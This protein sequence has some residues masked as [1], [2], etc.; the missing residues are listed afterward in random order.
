MVVVNR[1]QG[2]LVELAPPTSSRLVVIPETKK[3][4]SINID[5]MVTYAPPKGRLRVVNP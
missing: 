4:S 1:V 2:A 3:Q 5:R